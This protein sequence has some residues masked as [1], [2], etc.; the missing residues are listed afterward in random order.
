MQFPLPALFVSNSRNISDI[1]KLIKNLIFRSGLNGI[2]SEFKEGCMGDSFPYTWKY[3]KSKCPY[4]V[5]EYEP[6]NIKIKYETKELLSNPNT[7]GVC[8]HDVSEYAL[9]R[10]IQLFVMYMMNKKLQAYIQP[11]LEYHSYTQDSQKHQII[12]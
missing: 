11:T 9:K 10:Y 4:S 8:G 7:F 5:Y 3:K 1:Q 6:Y 12:Y 2:L